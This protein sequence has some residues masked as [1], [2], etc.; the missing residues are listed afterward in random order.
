MWEKKCYVLCG[1]A[2]CHS[3]KIVRA[4]NVG[5]PN[6]V[7]NFWTMSWHKLT[8]Y[9][10]ML[11]LWPFFLWMWK[12]WC[13]N[14]CHEG[15]GVIFDVLICDGFLVNDFFEWLLIFVS[16]ILSKTRTFWCMIPFWMRIF[17]PCLILLSICS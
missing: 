5:F 10:R 12:L 6:M 14:G 4:L 9:W 3:S 8:A 15:I 11:M 7:S 1:I 17:L 2:N 13:F 16:K